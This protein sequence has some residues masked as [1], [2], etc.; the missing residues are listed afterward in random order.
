M[1]CSDLSG[2]LLRLQEPMVPA[3]EQ[4][5]RLCREVSAVPSL[6]KIGKFSGK[7]KSG[8]EW[9]LFEKSENLWIK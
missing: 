1:F 9:K 8:I 7:E 5:D 4:R 2:A 6:G 3:R